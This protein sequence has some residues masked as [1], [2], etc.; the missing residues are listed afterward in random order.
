[1]ALNPLE[2]LKA[3][4]TIDRLLSLETKFTALLEVQAKEIQDL[5]DRLT[6]LEAREEILIAEAKGAG[7]E[8]TVAASSRFGLF[9]SDWDSP[10]PICRH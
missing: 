2:W 4:R 6:K 7:S 3:A 9:C 1:M 8:S 10:L 5:K